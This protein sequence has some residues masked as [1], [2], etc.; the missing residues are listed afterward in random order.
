MPS[1]HVKGSPLDSL[2]KR[3]KT[4]E[5]GAS[6]GAL[7]EDLYLDPT[8]IARHRTRKIRLS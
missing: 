3:R 4:E 8:W 2:R 6:S 1:F 5:R 7:G